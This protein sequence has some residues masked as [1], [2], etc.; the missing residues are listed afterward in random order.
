MNYLKFCFLLL[1]SLFVCTQNMRGQ[2]PT[3]SMYG[4]MVKADVK[5]NY[6]YSLGEAKKL[7]TEQHKL[8]FVNCFVDWALPCHGMN[9]YVFSDADFSAYMDKTFVNLFVDMDSPQGKELAQQYEVQTYAHYLILDAQGHVVLRIIGGSR[10]PQFKETVDLALNEKTS[11]AGARKR[12]EQGDHSKEALY[13]YLRALDLANERAVFDSIAPG[14]VRFL[15]NKDLL[16]PKNQLFW[17]KAIPDTKCNA[18]NYMVT[19]KSAFAQRVGA[20]AVDRFIESFYVSDAMSYA[21]GQKPYDKQKMENLR[22]EL[23]RAALPDT[24]MTCVF[25][26]IAQLRGQKKYKELLAYLEQNGQ[27]LVPQLTT[28]ELSLAQSELSDSD[29]ALVSSYLQ[30]AC[31]RLSSASAKYEYKSVIDKLNGVQPSGIAFEDGSFQELLDKARTEGKLVF[32]DCYTTWCGP[33]R[34]MASRVFTRKDVGDYFNANFV[35]GKM[36]MEK[37]EGL[38]LAKRYKVEAFPTMLLLDADGNVVDRLL[39]A[40]SGEELIEFVRKQ[41]K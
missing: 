28:M 37:G 16:E 15:K 10:L 36:D 39:G 33:C 11:L 7:A 22:S 6:V 35:C 3:E 31:E 23:E 8:I 12:Y 27:Y 4:D 40:C 14:Y 30:R 17:S 18:Y 29:K 41:K 38:H 2:L 25:F 26:Q 24:C 32:L 20:E 1:G 9:K 21:M 19:H 34:M 13:N 5:M